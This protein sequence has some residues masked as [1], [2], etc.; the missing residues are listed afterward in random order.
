MQTT[1]KPI[2]RSETANYWILRKFVE[3]I[4]RGGVRMMGY[5]FFNLQYKGDTMES[6]LHHWVVFKIPVRQNLLFK[7][8]QV[9]RNHSWLLT[10]LSSG[11][12]G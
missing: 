6:Q 9:D 2:N 5:L 4:K 12:I 8:D 7:T 10:N 3:N 1:S 11:D